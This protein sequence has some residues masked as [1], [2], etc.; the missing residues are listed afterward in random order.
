MGKEYGYGQMKH[1][2][3]APDFARPT[4]AP[5]IVKQHQSKNDHDQAKSRAPNSGQ[6]KGG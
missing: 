4:G 6:T 3:K 5:P 2:D 1:S